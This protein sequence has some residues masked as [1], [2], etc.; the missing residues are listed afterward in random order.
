[1]GLG[2]TDDGWVGS[3]F[4][5][6]LDSV[7]NKAVLHP[8]T[9][10]YGI[11][12]AKSPL[13]VEGFVIMD[14]CSSTPM[15]Q[16]LQNRPGEFVEIGFVYKD[17][18]FAALGDSQV[19]AKETRAMPS[20][21]MGWADFYEETFQPLDPDDPKGPRNRNVVAAGLLE[22]GRPFFL[23]A[24]HTPGLYSVDLMVGD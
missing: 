12:P 11:D 24:T 3:V 2:H 16:K 18:F 22:D 10:V 6:P 13:L 7:P 4:Y 1:L 23:H 17:D 5:R 9:F 21:V 15:L 19:T 14:E 20:L 8:A